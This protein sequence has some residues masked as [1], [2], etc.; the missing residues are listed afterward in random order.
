MRIVYI[1]LKHHLLGSPFVI[2]RPVIV[3]PRMLPFWEGRISVLL[4]ISGVG[5]IL[6]AD[7]IWNFVVFVCIF[8]W[9]SNLLIGT[10]ALCVWIAMTFFDLL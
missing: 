8:H 9:Y 2:P 7:I 3:R 5:L 6:A 10:I 1:L 4:I